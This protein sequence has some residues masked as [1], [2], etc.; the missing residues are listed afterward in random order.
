[1]KPFKEIIRWADF[2]R[3]I[4]EEADKYRAYKRFKKEFDLREEIN[5]PKYIGYWENLGYLLAV[6]DL[7]QRR[8]EAIIGR[9]IR[10]S[11]ISLVTL[12]TLVGSG[13]KAYNSNDEYEI[14]LNEVIYNADLNKDGKIKGSKEVEKFYCNLP[15]GFRF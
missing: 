6:Q 12:A 5:D 10:C 13:F 14:I 15:P 8:K 1:M 4:T 7:K 9:V 3:R 11:L 2:Y